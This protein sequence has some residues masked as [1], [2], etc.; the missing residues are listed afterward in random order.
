MTSTQLAWLE[1]ARKIVSEFEGCVLKAYPDPG[2]ADGE[3][4]TIGYGHTGPDVKQGMTI[5]KSLAE[6]FLTIDLKSA[7]ATVFELLPMVADFNPYQQAAL[8]SFT[9]NIGSGALADSTLRKR[10]FERKDPPK[11]IVEEEFPRW[12][13]GGDGKVL[14][15]LVRRRNA[16]INLFRQIPVTTEAKPPNPPQ[17]VITTPV[18]PAGMV[19]TKMRPPLK[20]GDHHLIANDINET[21]TCYLHSGTK[22]WTIPCLC[23]GQGGDTEWEQTAEDTPPGLYLVGRVYRDYEMDPSANFS[24]DRRAYG[25]YSFDLIG[26]EGQEGP[27][28]RY[29]RD[30]IMIHGGGSACGW[31]GAWLPMQQLFPTL[32]CIRLHNQH[33]RD[34]ILPLLG[35]GKIWVSVLQ[36]AK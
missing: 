36:E 20:P 16:E 29:G 13:K 10:L 32:G 26:Q 18:W 24:A 6:G 19:G 22:A 5:S 31:P 25:W 3:P 34:N 23:R 15:G 21:M 9:Y 35:S 1:P 14:P 30:G 27:G 7:A 33:L 11:V 8:V 4:W 12:N 2:S 17:T 28:S